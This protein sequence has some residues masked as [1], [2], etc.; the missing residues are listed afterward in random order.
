VFVPANTIS[1]ATGAVNSRV[2][3]VDS[4]YAQVLEIGSHLQND[5][6]QV[7]LSLGGVT[8]NGVV[9]RT[10]YT[11][12]HVRDQSS[13]GGGGFGGGSG[14]GGRGGGGGGT[15]SGNPNVPSGV[16]AAWRGAIRF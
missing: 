13:L 16:V 10:S 6:K 5:S 7:T 8:R 14:F 11:W 15:T 1:P 4:S 2:S 12:S 3:R 9:I